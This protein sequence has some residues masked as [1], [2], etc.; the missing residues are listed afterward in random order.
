MNCLKSLYLLSIIIQGGGGK[1][2]INTLYLRVVAL[3][4]AYCSRNITYYIVLWRGGGGGA[5]DDMSFSH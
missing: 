4:M 5:G 2:S 3:Q 1:V